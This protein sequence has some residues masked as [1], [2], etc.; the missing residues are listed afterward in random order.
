MNTVGRWLM[1]ALALALVGAVAATAWAWWRGHWAPPPPWNPWAPLDL[2]EAPNLLTSYKLQRLEGSPERCLAALGASGWRWAPLPDRETGPGCGLRNAVRI[3]AMDV[4]VGPAFSLSCPAAVSLAL[5]ERH[6]L[7]P[8]A[9]AHLGSRV[10][11]L[12]HF[13]SYACRN[14]YGRAQGRRSQHAT[15]EAFDVAGFVTAD[16]QRVR[17]ASDWRGEAGA[18]SFLHAVHRGACRF[19]DG[20]LGPD[21]N[22]AHHDHLHLDRGPFRVCR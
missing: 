14:V 10:V 1:R 7:Q 6:V 19:F 8:E 16:G 15:A 12:E 17:V 20:T 5:W 21:Y 3:E 4:A 11:R 13:G 2:A 22:Q 18:A 9:Q